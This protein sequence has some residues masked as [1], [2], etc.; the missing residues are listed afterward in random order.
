MKNYNKQ[1]RLLKNKKEEYI[2]LLKTY[3]QNFKTTFFDLD[4]YLQ[5][6]K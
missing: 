1:A 6:T 3:Q 4:A 2:E 5:V